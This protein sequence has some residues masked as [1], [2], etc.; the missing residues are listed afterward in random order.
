[1]EATRLKLSSPEEVGMKTEDLHE[2]DAVILNGMIAHAYPG[3]QVLVTKDGKVI[4]NKP[5]GTKI[6][7][8]TKDKVQTTDLYDLASISKIAATTVAVMKLYDEKKIDINQTVGD[9]L[10]LD[11]SA[12]IKK[13]KISDIMTH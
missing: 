8:N 2:M 4:W 7:E 5:Y 11:E 12:T 9:Y 6:Y 10:A 1:M 3:C 13:L